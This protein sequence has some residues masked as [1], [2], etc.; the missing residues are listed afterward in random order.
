MNNYTMSL[1]AV[2]QIPTIGQMDLINYGS[3]AQEA[4]LSKSATAPAPAG[5]AVYLDPASNGKPVQVL[6]V[7]V[8]TQKPFGFVA[9]SVIRATALAGNMVTVCRPNGVLYVL[10]NDT[11]AAGDACEFEPTTG[12][13]IK[14]GGTNPVCGYAIDAATANKIFRMSVA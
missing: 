7:T 6:P 3:S 1:N 8:A 11:I 12:M 9:F 13:I 14:S 2:K 5:T 4:Q 10:A